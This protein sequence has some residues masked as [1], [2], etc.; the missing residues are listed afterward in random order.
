MA[1][2]NS[3]TNYYYDRGRK[4]GRFLPSND[5]GGFRDYVKREVKRDLFTPPKL[6]RK[7]FGR[8]LP[9]VKPGF[10]SGLGTAGRFALG[11]AAWLLFEFGDDLYS[12]F[13]PHAIHFPD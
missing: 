10:G 13:K 6:P 3:S 11:P 12:Y 7:D 9:K 2:N 5:F 4:A 1:K 8:K